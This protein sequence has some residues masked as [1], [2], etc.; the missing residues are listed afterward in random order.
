M[1]HTPYGYRIEEGHAVIDEEQAERVKALYRGYL[2]GLALMPAAK[3][4]GIETWHGSAKRLLQ[5]PTAASLRTVM[6]SPQVMKRRLSITRHLSKR[7]PI[8]NLPGYSQMMES[9][10]RIPGNGKNLTA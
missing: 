6:S 2:S 4:A 3:Q 7:I 1:G 8:G 10:E 9:P 5:M